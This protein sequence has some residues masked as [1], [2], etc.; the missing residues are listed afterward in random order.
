[1][2]D[3]DG[4]QPRKRLDRRRHIIRTFEPARGFV[5][6]DEMRGSTRRCKQRKRLWRDSRRCCDNRT[7]FAQRVRSCVTRGIVVSLDDDIDGSLSGREKFVP[8]DHCFRCC[9]SAEK[10][11]HSPTSKDERARLKCGGC[12]LCNAERECHC[13]DFITQT[14]EFKR[15]REGIILGTSV[16]V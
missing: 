11:D 16:D 14:R 10:C 15:Q 8:R 3:A 9:T 12:L 6:H 2:N 1:V 5:A 4:M 7:H 13:N